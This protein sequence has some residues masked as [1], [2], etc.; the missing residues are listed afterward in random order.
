MIKGLFDGKRW[1]A[2]FAAFPE[3]Y[4]PGFLMTLRISL[5]GLAVALVLGVLFGMF[6]TSKW[7]LLKIIS[8]IYV[9]DWATPIIFP[10]KSSIE[11]MPESLFTKRPTASV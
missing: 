6:S 3:Y 5:V 2:L 10:S 4:I 7:K 11:L 1:S 8:R 9:E